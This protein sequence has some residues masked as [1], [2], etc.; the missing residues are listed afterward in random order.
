LPGFFL[1]DGDVDRFEVAGD[2]G[3]VAAGGIA[4]GGADEVDDADSLLGAIAKFGQ[5]TINEP[6]C[7]G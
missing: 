4:Q 5:L 7:E 2:L 1:I 3:P 6:C